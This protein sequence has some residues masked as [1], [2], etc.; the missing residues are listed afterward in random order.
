MGTEDISTESILR[1]IDVLIFEKFKIEGWEPLPFKCEGITRNDLAKFMGEI[2]YKNGAEIGVL[3]GAYS[4]IL[5]ELIPNLKLKCIDPYLPF[6]RNTKEKMEGHFIRARK[7]LRGFNVEFIRKP[8]ME[9]VREI[10]DKSLDFVYIDA[11]HEFDP[12]M[13]DLICWSDKVR[14]GGMVAGHDYSEP[15]WWNGVMLAVD[16]YTKAHNI[17]K[18]YIT[19]EEDKSFFWVKP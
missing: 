1:E 17:L 3:R 8:S 2:G 18:W 14:S 5:C 15:N 7:R 10:P 12:V 9:V 11:M 16:T 13:I 6:R 19:D 4:R